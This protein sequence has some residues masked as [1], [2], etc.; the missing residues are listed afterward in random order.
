M[1]EELLKVAEP[2][3]ELDL[4]AKAIAEEFMD[5]L[6]K[7]LKKKFGNAREGVHVSDL[8][9]RQIVF[10]DLNPGIELSSTDINNF[11]S[12]KA[13]GAAIESISEEHK[14]YSTEHFT[15]IAHFINGHIDVFNTEKNI[16]VEFK[17]YRGRSTDKLPKWHQMD[18]LMGYMSG[19]N[20]EWGILVYQLLFKFDDG[21]FIIEQPIVSKKGDLLLVE[22]GPFALF[23]KHMTP[24]ERIVFSKNKAEGALQFVKARAYGQPALAPHVMFDKNLD[25]LC[26][27]CPFLKPCREM[28]AGAELK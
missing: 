13:I 12:G 27:K 14:K 22:F 5:D 4:I 2:F 23:V 6:R 1:A 28:N 15:S 8:C 19:R 18:Q 25:W 10:R 20:A 11:T 17:S 7:G 9:Y 16:P 24:E 3:T 26:K 21:E